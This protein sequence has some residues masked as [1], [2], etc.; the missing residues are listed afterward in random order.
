MYM[1]ARAD[2]S[3]VSRAQVDAFCTQFLGRFKGIAKAREGAFMTANQRR[4]VPLTFPTGLRK[5]LVPGPELKGTTILNNTVQATAAAGLKMALLL[6][7]ERGLSQYL[8]AVV[9]DEIILT[10]P[11]ELLAE[12]RPQLELAMIDGM[13]MVTDAPVAVESK[14]DGQSW[15]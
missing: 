13:T 14:G 8:S 5:I 1:K 6:L 4:P 12:L 9:H 2:G 15:G 3:K 10:P 11:K 7:K